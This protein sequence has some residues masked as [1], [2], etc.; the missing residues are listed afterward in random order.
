MLESMDNVHGTDCHSACMFRVDDSVTNEP[1]EK[2]TED[3]TG[4]F[5]DKTGNALDTTTARQTAN[6][7]LG[8][9]LNVVTKHL[10]MAFATLATQGIFHSFPTARHDVFLLL[11][12]D[13]LLRYESFVL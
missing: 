2:D 1:L 4:L 10:A 3:T 9:A 12:V 11:V 8:N 6:G 13:L 7:R 5:V